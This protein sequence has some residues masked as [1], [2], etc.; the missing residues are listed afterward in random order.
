MSHLRTLVLSFVVLLYSGWVSALGLGDLKLNS[1][2]NE[3]FDAEVAVLNAGELNVEQLFAKLASG[4]DFERAGVDRELYL[5]DLRFKLDMSKPGKPVIRVTSTKPVREPYLN[6]L[7]QLQ[8][9]SGRLLKEYTVFLDLPVFA[10][11]QSSPSSR[12]AQSDSPVSSATSKKKDTSAPSQSETS[13]GFVTGSSSSQ[14]G[15]Y[16]VQ[17][18]DTLWGIASQNRPQGSSI[19][20]AMQAIYE[21]N[22][23]AFVN[24]NMNVLK[25]G[26]VLDVPD[27]NAISAV[28]DR[29]AKN[30][31]A[32]SAEAL[33]DQL[34]SPGL[35]SSEPIES[36]APE[37]PTQ[38]DGVLRLL[39]ADT[40]A[41]S[42]LGDAGDPSSEGVAGEVLEN[43]LAI[44]QEGL[45]KSTRENQELR[46][47]IAQ[48]EE[49]L[50]TM[51]RLVELG[52]DQLSAIQQGLGKED[53]AVEED[54]SALL[55]EDASALP[56]EDAS[57][58][59]EEDGSALAEE[60]E[61]V[62]TS[63]DPV[64]ASEEAQPQGLLASFRD[65]F[66]II[67]AGL[68]LVVL[69]AL[70]LLSRR[71]KDEADTEHLATD[72]PFSFD[73]RQSGLDAGG[74]DLVAR[75]DDIDEDDQLSAT[76]V[77]NDFVNA[78]DGLAGSEDGEVDPIGEADIYLS[79]GDYGQAEAVIQRALEAEPEDSRLHLKLL[80]L[81]SDQSDIDRFDGHYPQLVA[82]GDASAIQSADRI[83]ESIAIE[84]DEFHEELLTPPEDS[85]PEES[86]PEESLEE[87]FA[88]PAFEVE[89]AEQELE[90]LD[91]GVN[92]LD[93]DLESH[94]GL[95]L[96][97][98]VLDDDSDLDNEDLDLDLDLDLSES[99]EVESE[100]KLDLGYDQPDLGD[101]ELDIDPGDEVQIELDQDAADSKSEFDDFDIEAD[102][103][104]LIEGDEI[105]TQ[106]EL[107]QAYIDMGDKDGARDILN[108]VLANGN[109][110][111]QAQAQEILTQTT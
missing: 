48:L 28:D 10:G 8:W 105:T 26:A 16:R 63:A 100:Q 54:A 87:D 72:K 25:K 51:S 75:A 38:S 39:S 92:I 98:L 76:D 42:G 53:S 57:A 70:F 14:T 64:A 45:S 82:L 32:L 55:G 73:D 46:E 47:K 99:G 94:E 89:P 37:E 56:E 106:L 102:L 41:S 15:S 18:G 13:T 17:S 9:P 5:L 21:R 11:K 84:N 80:S 7:I 50:S 111:Q 74:S 85:Q 91:E 23:A 6:F 68:L 95:P 24:G 78:D 52:D 1:S 86:L 2:L 97:T 3:P 101:I 4:E 31:V 35:I 43:D 44:A 90:S 62:D 34:E 22:G 61:E 79:F 66:T 29:L 59:A 49:Q 93:E 71:R 58:L 36:V 27:A 103:D 77:D 40:G 107:A 81:F 88:E 12:I 20:Q 109:P 67:A 33:Q 108:D 65:K 69:G 19:H 30:Q 96:E 83:R 104:S 110:E 60:L